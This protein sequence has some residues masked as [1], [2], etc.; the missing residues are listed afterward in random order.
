M[1]IL[2]ISDLHLEEPKGIEVESVLERFYDFVTENAKG[3]KFNQIVITGD[4]RNS[5]NEI[6]VEG[7]IEVINRIAASANVSDKR[8]IHI[9]P[10][11]H[12]LNRREDKEIEEIRKK[13][14]YTN[15]TFHDAKSDLPIMINR[16]NGF[17]W[18]LCEQYYK[19]MN[20]WSEWVHNPHYLAIYEEYALV[21]VNSTLCCISNSHDGNLIIGTAY[22]KQL[23][24]S[25]VAHNLNNVF[26]FAHHPIQNMANLEE[27]TLDNLLKS[28]ADMKFYWICGDA[29]RNRQSPREY[30]NL[31]QVGSLTIS[32]ELIPDFAIYDVHSTI[33]ERKVFRYLGHLN[34]PAKRGKPAGGWKRVYIDK[35]APSVYY[36][37]TLE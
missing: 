36:D 10:G 28:Y 37:E 22:L 16:L 34:N 27:T 8:Q 17:F 2:H 19:K 33:T 32:K 7:A 9:I 11:N 3:N 6:S 26:F 4:I 31:Y 30:I 20:P 1:R 5:K 24:D 21:F 29:H 23:I 14:D 25:A 35:K 13:Y 18:N 15:G 12:D